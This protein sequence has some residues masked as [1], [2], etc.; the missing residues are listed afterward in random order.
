[1]EIT[2]RWWWEIRI[3]LYVGTQITVGQALFTR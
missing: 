1:M 3:S 2:Q